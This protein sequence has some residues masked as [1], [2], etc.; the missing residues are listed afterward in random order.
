MYRGTRNESK[1]VKDRENKGDRNL[2]VGKSKYH[3]SVRR[4]DYV[5]RKRWSRLVCSG[6]AE[7]KDLLHSAVRLVAA[8]QLA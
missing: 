7:W 8:T 6:S 5:L 3:L 2:G 4:E 1:R